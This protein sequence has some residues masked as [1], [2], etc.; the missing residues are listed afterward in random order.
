[1]PR[2]HSPLRIARR[3]A[4]ILGS[5]ERPRSTLSTLR[6]SS[7]RS[8]YQGR[9]GGTRALPHLQP[10]DYPYSISLEFLVRGLGRPQHKIVPRLKVAVDSLVD[11]PG[12]PNVEPIGVRLVDRIESR[13]RP[14]A[15]LVPVVG[16]L[17]VIGENLDNPARSDSAETA[18]LDH[19][20]QLGFESRKAANP[21]LNFGKARPGD[22]V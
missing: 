14:S 2:G 22:R 6:R 4:E 20:F 21:L 8:M 5:S 12:D 9:K 7:R 3:K 11:P 19:Q 15:A 18:S 13:E 17:A 1:M 16:A 10:D